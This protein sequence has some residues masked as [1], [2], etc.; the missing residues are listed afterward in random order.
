[1][2]LRGATGDIKWSY[3]TAVAFGPWLL[4]STGDSATL[5]GTVAHVDD[6]RATQTPLVASLVIGRQRL[7]YPVLDLQIS[8]GVV[9]ATLG[10]AQEGSK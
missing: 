6:Y 1:M 7:V 2:T 3:L 9:T 10:A 4:E 5:K 8:G